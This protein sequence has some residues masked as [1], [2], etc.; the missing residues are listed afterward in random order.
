M[1]RTIDQL[2][3]QRLALARFAAETPQFDNPLAAWEV[4]ALRDAVLGV[5]FEIYTTQSREPVPGS[6]RRD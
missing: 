5:P 2:Y 6:P 1:F 4:E 3:L